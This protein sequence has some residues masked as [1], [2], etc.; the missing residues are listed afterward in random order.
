[1]RRF[2]LSKNKQSGAKLPKKNRKN[3]GDIPDFQSASLR[4]CHL[5]FLRDAAWLHEIQFRERKEVVRKEDGLIK[6]K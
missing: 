6:N 1:M 3:S 2:L 5:L 4:K